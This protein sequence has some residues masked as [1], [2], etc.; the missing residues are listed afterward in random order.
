MA[1]DAARRHAMQPEPS[2][3]SWMLTTPTGP[4]RRSAFATRSRSSAKTLHY[5]RRYHTL[6]KLRA[7]RDNEVT[8]HAWDSVPMTQ[9]PD[10][11]RMDAVASGAID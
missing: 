6:R 3:R 9:R 4:P 1:L 11:L 8:S 7:A 2:A 10:I 5:R